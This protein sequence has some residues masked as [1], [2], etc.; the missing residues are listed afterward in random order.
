MSFND[1]M[2]AT[3]NFDPTNHIGEGGF[4]KVFK[5]KLVHGNVNEHSTIVVKKL[6]K[7]HGQG[8]Q[9]YYN[10]LRILCEYNHENVIGL[11]G[12]SNETNEKLIVYEYASKGSLDKHLNNA[13]LTWRNR[14]KICIDVATGLNFLHEG[15]QGQE[16]IIYKDSEVVIHRDI[17]S[18]N[19][20]L[21]DDWKA[22]IGDFGLSLRS[23]LNEET[24]FFIDHPC[25]TKD[26]VDPLYFKS[27][28]LSAKSDVY[29]LGV[30]FFEILSGRA[31]YTLPKHETQSL[32]S[33][34]KYE[35]E[36]KKRN[37]VV[38]RAI[39]EEIAP[40][41]LTTYLDIV[42]LCLNDDE[43]IRPTTR[44]VLAELQKALKFQD[45]KNEKGEKDEKN[46]KDK[47]AEKTCQEDHQER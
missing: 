23:T 10:E 34:M 46:N 14:L 37:D 16:I 4:G 15:I 13:S 3:Q 25:G 18:A 32:L 40:K 28:I 21:F 5:G 39:S 9:Q 44:I 1:I 35:F 33:F 36:S 11:I 2:L 26:Y 19:I 6:D 8:E 31:T 7:R 29:S 41:S 30:V 17:K 27:G 22:K 38:F 45:E 43:E 20:L 42:Y 47:E 24:N 12:Y